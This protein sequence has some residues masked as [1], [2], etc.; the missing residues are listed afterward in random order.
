MYDEREEE[1][2]KNPWSREMRNNVG[3]AKKRTAKAPKAVHE[4]LMLDP[5]FPEVSQVENG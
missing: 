3:R 5:I 1:K 4:F 2:M